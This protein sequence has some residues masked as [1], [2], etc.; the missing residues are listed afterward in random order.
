M[1]ESKNESLGMSVKR[2][3]DF[4]RWYLDVVRKGG[5]VD[6]RSPLKGF[7][8]ILPWGY[9]IWEEIMHEF[10]CL[11]KKHGVK[12]AYFPLLIPESLLK[13]EEEHLKGFRAETCMVTEAGNDKMEERLAVRP[14][15]ETI[16]YAMFSLWIRSHK[17]LPLKINQWCNVVRWDTKV[18][19][20]LIRGREFL[21]QEGHT[22][23][24]T[25]K[26]AVHWI[27]NVV[28]MYKNIYDMLAIEPLILVRPKSDTF[29]GA[30]FSVVFDTLLQDGK[31]AQGPGT[32]MLGQHF[33]KSFDITFVDQHE[34]KQHVWQ[35]SW[36]MSTRQLG[37]LIMHHG[38]DKGA[39]LPPSIVPYQAVIIPILF[40]GK[41]N[42]VLKAAA[43]IKTDLEKAGIRV[44]FDERNY[45]AGFKFNEAELKGIPLRIEIGPKDIEKKQ[46]TLVRRFDSKKETLAAAKLKDTIKI[47]D[48]MQREM[49]KKSQVFLKQN[50]HD[51]TDMKKLKNIFGFARSNWCGSADC[52]IKLKTETGFEIRGTLYNKN[53]KP[54]NNCI[55]CG[56][57]AK[58]VIYIAK[59]Y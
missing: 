56:T 1:N 4:S 38:D 35:T 21:W 20:P 53:E 19:K 51:V 41:E 36:G 10:D 45:S 25:E 17:D 31:V 26:D 30:N 44:F 22:A 55:Y 24:A 8:V 43:K 33:S 50:I 28:T 37:I 18:T 48:N 40:K 27:D 49:L 15:S 16:M 7:D 6:Q 39:I 23:H 5:F 54:F 14:T 12:N 11:I 29:A 52:E 57:D 46:I 59:A 9:A 34:K 32:H 58:H 13:K 42:A 47:L 2:S 3:E